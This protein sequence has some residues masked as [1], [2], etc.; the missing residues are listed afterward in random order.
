MMKSDFV[1]SRTDLISSAAQPKISSEQSEDFVAKLQI[2]LKEC[3][4]TEY[5]I[6]IALRAAYNKE[7][8]KQ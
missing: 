1:G 7:E 6:E 8:E 5:W 2:A 4:E 3:Y